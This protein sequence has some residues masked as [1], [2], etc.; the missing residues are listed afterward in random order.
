MELLQL[1][2]FLT[3]AQYQHMTKAAEHLQIAQ[4]ALS[5]AIHRLEAELGVTLFERKNRSIELNDAG[6]LLQKRLL[7]L[8]S[9]LDR[10]PGELKEGQY[11]ASHT[12]HLKLLAASTLI[13]NRIIAYRAL[14]PDVN[15]QLYQSADTKAD[16]DLCV[17]AV[18][19]DLPND[20][21]PNAIVMLEEE[22]YLAVPAHSPY[23]DKDSIRL[24]ETRNAGYICLAGS[25]PIRQICNSYFSEAD[26]TPNVIFES[27][28]T[29]SV[30]NL[31][32]AGLGIGFWP[33]Y[34]WGP[35]TS[36]WGPMSAHSPVKL[37]PIRDQVCRR[38]IIL[39]CSPHG[40]ANPIVKDFCNFLIQN[41]KWL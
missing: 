28:T 15:F 39:M 20:E 33:Q 22:L 6:R 4:P 13:T 7:P 38:Q 5:Q 41:S 40:V 23:G 29:E 27:D 24:S 19:S 30:R 37:L 3:A 26:F 11:H 36:D 35:L 1:R 32:A 9:A 16:F 12:I 18:R 34:S 21:Y 25:R 2:Y 8:I 14:R 17:S 10:I 31:I